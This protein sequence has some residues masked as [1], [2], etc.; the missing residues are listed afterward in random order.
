VNDSGGAASG[1]SI[2]AGGTLTSGGIATGGILSSGGLAATGGLGTGGI[3]ATGGSASSGG[4]VVKPP[5]TGA[6]GSANN[7]CVPAPEQCNGRD[8]DCNGRVDEVSPVPCPGG[9]FSYCVGGRQSACPS[10]CEVCVPGSER[11]CFVSFCT[12][13]GVQTCTADGRSFG[14]CREERVPS[15]C[16]GVGSARNLGALERCC[17]DH[18]Y[19]CVDSEDL[20]HDGNRAEMLGAC[21]DVQCE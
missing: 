11:I 4:S 1:G 7:G 3:P 10:R 5:P 13:W 20:D 16:A 9:G 14:A 17:L 21:G 15:E 19:C 6:G 2:G 12:F 18:G 8:D